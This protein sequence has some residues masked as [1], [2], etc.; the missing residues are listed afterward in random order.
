VKNFSDPVSIILAVGVALNTVMVMNSI[1][2]KNHTMAIINF[3]SGLFLIFAYE[4]RRN[5]ND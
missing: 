2:A 1:V 4:K 5:K 3:L